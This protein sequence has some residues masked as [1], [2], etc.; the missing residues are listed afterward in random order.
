MKLIRQYKQFSDENG[1]DFNAAKKYLR[2]LTNTMKPYL[3]E[4]EVNYLDNNNETN[5]TVH[6]N[7]PIP[8]GF[9]DK[10]PF[11][12]C[13]ETHV[14]DC[15]NKFIRAYDYN[16]AECKN[17][18]DILDKLRMAVRASET[19]KSLDEKYGW[20]GRKS[21]ATR[22]VDEFS[23]YDQKLQLIPVGS[24]LLFKLRSWWYISF[25]VVVEDEDMDIIFV[26]HDL[27][28][29]LRFINYNA[30]D[31]IARWKLL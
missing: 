7:I 10:Y 14:D 20:D 31:Q 5:D 2:D 11:V 6:V 12:V 19:Y 30:L 1:F 26:N 9:T 25:V 15:I 22:D 4:F 16:N 27:D 24:F 23:V 18:L 29:S 21:Y 3:K 17:N 28:K 8:A 13:Q